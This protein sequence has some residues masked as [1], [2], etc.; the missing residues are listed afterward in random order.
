MRQ[1]LLSLLAL[2]VASSSLFAQTP[3]VRKAQPVV[4]PA[5]PAPVNTGSAEGAAFRAGEAFELR[6]SGMPVEDAAQF[7][8]Q[9]TIGGDG[10]INIPLAGQIRAAG[11]TQ[12]Q[13]ERA[14]ERKLVDER[15]FTRPTAT[16][17]VAPSARFIT[18][19]GQVRAPQRMA[20]TADLTL[21]S[22]LVSAG[23]AGDFAGDKVKLT[24]GG[25]VTIFSRK[26]LAKTPEEDPKLLPGDMIEQL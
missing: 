25:K 8:Q 3:T 13:L 5:A 21:N 26:R 20:W 18:I 17:I 1:L 4:R 22:A 19:G 11:L 10:F 16:I 12:S 24:R 2:S 15:I 7:S 6:L 14:I 23:G 9:F